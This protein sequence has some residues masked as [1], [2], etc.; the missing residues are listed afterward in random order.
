MNLNILGR[1]CR[2][3]AIGAILFGSVSCID[4]ND[5][6]GE[7]FI[8]TDQLWD[9]FPCEAEV[10][11]NIELLPADKLSGYS[12]TR[13]VFGSIS[14]GEFSSTNSTSF[15][16]V[17][18]ADSLDFGKQ[19]DGYPEIIQFH[20][21]AARDTTSVLHDDQE[22]ILQNVNVY[23]LSKPLDATTMYT[24]SDLNN[25]V[26]FSKRITNGIPVY[27]G[28]DS[29]SFDFSK[30]FARQLMDGV[31][32]FQSLRGPER[33]SIKYYIDEVPGIYISSDAQTGKGGRI[34]MFGVK[35][36]VE[37]Q[38]LMGN[39]AE[40]KIRGKYDYSDEP[41]DTAFIFYYGPSKFI[42]DGDNSYPPQYALNTSVTSGT[43]SLLQTWENNKENLFV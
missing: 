29:L 34:N 10:L 13:L 19:E 16:L 31:L 18:F 42:A 8:P 11:E 23:S 9:V 21:S 12:T 5:S 25:F 32:R 38:Y 1:V 26:D 17:P 4:V 15:T 41:V 2:A 43:E 27:S 36:D 7:N 14:D 3:A 22:K 28:G 37:S 33:D 35:L 39:F 24:G 6:F 40:L 20:F 30:E